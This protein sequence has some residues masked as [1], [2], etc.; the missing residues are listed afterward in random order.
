MCAWLELF[1]LLLLT[2]DLKIEPTQYST[3]CMKMTQ[4]FSIQLFNFG[5]FAI[6]L[7][8]FACNGE[9]DFFCDFQ[10]PCSRTEYKPDL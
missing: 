3:H 9:L 8:H 5:I 7:A 1:P 4:S 6:F 10:T 2:K